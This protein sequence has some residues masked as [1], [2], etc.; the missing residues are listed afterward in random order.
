MHVKENEMH[1]NQNSMPEPRVAT[2][3]EV[4]RILRISRNGAYQAA[5]RGDFPTVRI[6]KRILVPL[7]AIER[8]LSSNA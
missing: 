5:K 6:G 8:L 4:A 7:A 1:V 2:L 3:D